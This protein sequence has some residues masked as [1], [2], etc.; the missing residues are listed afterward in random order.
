MSPP[1]AK[2]EGGS[3]SAVIRQIPFLRR[4]S[5]KTAASWNFFQAFCVPAS[6]LA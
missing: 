1:Q 5:R 3:A 6:E 2:L 4:K